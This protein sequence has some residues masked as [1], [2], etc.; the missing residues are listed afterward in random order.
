VRAVL[1]LA[2]CACFFTIAHARALAVTEYC[3]A[4]VG[5]FHPLDGKE[6]ATLFSYDLSAE[7][8]RSVTGTVFAHTEDG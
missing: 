4:R 2:L 6:S 1:V 3:P 7:S 5:P 8:A